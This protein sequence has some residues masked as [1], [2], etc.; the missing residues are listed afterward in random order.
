MDITKKFILFIAIFSIGSFVYAQPIETL[1]SKLDKE[2][3]NYI[4]LGKGP[5][6][7]AAV[8]MGSSLV[9]SGQAGFSDLELGT[10]VSKNS[11]FR[12]GSITKQFTAAA[13][14]KLQ[15]LQRLSANDSILDYLEG[16]PSS[17]RS[18]KIS[19]LL[20]HTSGIENY[21]ETP[22]DID[23]IDGP[24]L[25]KNII[26]RIRNKNL[27][28]K[29]G[30]KWNYSN[31]NY[32]LLG[33][34]IEKASGKSY[35]SF[36]M[37]ELL[38]GLAPHSIS[39]CYTDRLI[40]NRA[41]GYAKAQSTDITGVWINSTFINMLTPFSAGALC[42]T[43][44]DLVRWN[45]ALSSGKIISPE[46]YA[47]MITNIKLTDGSPTNYGYGIG[48]L[49]GEDGVQIFHEGGIPGFRS[50]LVYYPEKKICIAIL[51][52]DE[53]EDAFKVSNILKTHIHTVEDYY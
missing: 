1:D 6:I 15:E 8:S 47:S 9:Y 42:A 33:M 31:T 35:D 39:Y 44:E 53:N 21:S 14:L 7:S 43:S 45:L 25:H 11:V 34:I 13:I 12:I 46:S 30:E 19:N 16:V 40:A 49:E 41:S 26:D 29:P 22:D 24:V 2:L 18:V 17:W 4:E 52:N 51:I 28:F 38:G 50:S 48:V 36:L 27:L 20:N 10:R 3:N 32:Y 37:G 23:R 5:G